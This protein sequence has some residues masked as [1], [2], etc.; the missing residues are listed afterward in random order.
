MRKLFVILGLCV[1]LAYPCCAK[2]KQYIPV[3]PY[4][5][6]NK[7]ISLEKV[8]SETQFSNDYI[9]IFKNKYKPCYSPKMGNIFVYEIRNI[10]GHNIT[11]K[12]VNSK[13]FYNRDRQNQH[14]KIVGNT[15]KTMF[16][17]WQYYTPLYDIYYGIKTDS[18]SAPFIRDF[19][20]NKTINANEALKI[21]TKS[22]RKYDN[23]QAE[24]VFIIDNEE[25][26]V[27][28]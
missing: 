27:K 17:S 13:E 25:K 1:F 20:V 6:Y 22:S 19:P 10:S 11:L 2:E 16:T 15:Y 24:F 23:P 28:F 18:E 3:L 21:L 5:E 9:Q 4:K 14:G 8:G 7:D 12:W 26:S